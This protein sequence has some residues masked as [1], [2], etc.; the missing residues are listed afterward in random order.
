M[1]DYDYEKTQVAIQQQGGGALN[2]LSMIHDDLKECFRIVGKHKK[3]IDKRDQD[4][5]E[6]IATLKAQVDNLTKQAA[7]LQ[8]RLWGLLAGV[9]LAVL[10]GGITW[11][12]T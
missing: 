5:G 2:P 6:D 8:T 12:T 10:G 7:V 11:L 1:K 9:I 4:Q 3:E